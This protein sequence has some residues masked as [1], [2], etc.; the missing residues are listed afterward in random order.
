MQSYLKNGLI[1]VLA[2]L[3]CFPSFPTP[4][5]AATDVT[6]QA[7]KAELEQQLADIEAQIQQFEKQ[8]NT[9]QGEK[10]TLTK[11]INKLRAQQEQLRLQIKATVLK[12]NDINVKLTTTEGQ[13]KKTKTKQERLHSEI[14]AVLKLLNSR[15]QEILLESL[16]SQ[17]GLADVAQSIKNYSTIFTALA[18][19]TNKAHALHETLKKQQVAYNDQQ[20]DAERLLQLK[21][22]AQSALVD[23]L[24][25]QKQLL[26]ETKGK[27]SNYQQI[28]TDARKRANAIRNRIYDLIGGETQ[29]TFEK[30]VEIA[31][32]VA[33][34]TSIRTA[35]LLAVLT[36]ESNLGKN[37]GTCNRA[38]DPPEKSWR[39]VMKPERD[40]EPFKT[41]TAELGKDPDV[42]PVSCPMKDSR[43]KQI[44]WGGAMGP[45]Q[46]I[47][48][49]WMG[50]RKRVAEIT[51]HSAN[52]WDIKDAFLAAALKL[53]GQG[54][55]SK[56]EQG[57]WTAAMK[58]F[59]GSVNLKYRFYGDNVA[60]T[61]KKYLGEIDQIRTAGYSPQ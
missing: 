19:L 25:E 13:I 39:V 33:K 21:S 14:G 32:W 48:S 52:P 45:A 44:G 41:I 37:V 54:A 51:G 5:H 40:Q 3:L 9:T 49:T 50:Y 58:Y 23:K 15:D 60:K 53:S 31:D 16:A 56:T 29:I 27:E 24:G 12:I 18:V 30:A 4:L 36:Q 38:G 2:V 57:E 59:A 26:E 35:F 8:L 1:F 28:L 55:A 7:S 11:A 22:A 34:Q 6:I 42:T 17:R 46:F 43:G 20:D 47:P 61:T 10:N